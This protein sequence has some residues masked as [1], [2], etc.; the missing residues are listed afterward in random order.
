MITQDTNCCIFDGSW[1]DPILSQLSRVSGRDLSCNLA[2]KGRLLNCVTAVSLLVACS[3]APYPQ[4]P[5]PLQEGPI[6]VHDVSNGIRESCQLTVRT[7]SRKAIRDIRLEGARY[8]ETL[9]LTPSATRANGFQ[10][11]RP[12]PLTSTSSIF[13]VQALSGCTPSSDAEVDK[14]REQVRNALAKSEGFFTLSKNREGLIL[15]SLRHELVA[16]MYF[17]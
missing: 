14:T 12:L 2:A 7:L 11:W 16:Y 15:V 9:D 5:G 10:P 3:S 17:G 4:L 6:L 1:R 8:L 13:A